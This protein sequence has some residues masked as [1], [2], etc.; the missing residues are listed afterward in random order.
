MIACTAI[1]LCP[2]ADAKQWNRMVDVSPTPDVY[3]RPEYVRANL[4]R[5]QSAVGLVLAASARRFLLPLILRPLAD[6]EFAEGVPGFDAITP[7]GYGGLLPLEDGSISKAEARELLA[8]LRRWCLEAG[9]VS[10]LIRLHP[11]TAQHEW[12]AG[13]ED[14]GVALQL[15]GET[16]AIDLGNWNEKQG[17]PAG[18]K[19]SRRSRLNLARR[20]LRLSLTLCDSEQSEGALHEF[21][22]IYEE[23]MALREASEFYF[24]PG[25]YYRALA[26]GLGEK[27]SVVLCYHGDEPVGGTLF[28]ADKLFA[29]YHLSGATVAGRRFNAHTLAIVT[30]GNWA[31]QRGCRWLHLGGGLQPGDSLFRFKDSFGATTF[32]YGFVKLVA[33]DQRY[34]Q[35]FEIRRSCPKLAPMRPDFFPAYRA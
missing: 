8:S 22:A 12:A 11:L 16:K 33:D 24:F 2:V 15:C 34:V 31:R 7:Y 26:Q 5:E 3:Y 29:H 13:A 10:C 18:L 6:L 27:M 14:E 19:G 25:N 21:R 20:E 9:V 35:L 23:T 30:G 28:F 1:S 17:I 32:R 4:S